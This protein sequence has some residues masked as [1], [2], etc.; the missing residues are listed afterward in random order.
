MRSAEVDGYGHQM[1][2]GSAAIPMAAYRQRASDYVGQKV[3]LVACGANI[4]LQTLRRVLE[5]A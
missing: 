4:S 2:E 3:V 1:I 5:G